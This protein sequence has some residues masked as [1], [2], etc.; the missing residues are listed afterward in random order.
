MIVGNKPLT[1]KTV[2]GWVLVVALLLITLYGITL[3]PFGEVMTWA[4]LLYVAFLCSKFEKAE[5]EEKKYKRQ[6]D[7]DVHLT[8]FL[9]QVGQHAN[10]AL[11]IRYGIANNTIND[12][13]KS[14]T[15]D[16]KGAMR[17]AGRGTPSVVPSK[18]ILL[19]KI[20]CEGNNRYI[21]ELSE[22]GDR[23]AKA[24]IEK[25]QEYVKT[26]LPL[27]DQWFEEYEK[28]EECLKH[29]KS[30]SLKEL[31]TFHIQFVLGSTNLKDGSCH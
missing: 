19:K 2:V 25:G 26:F 29:N 24:V 17:D 31:A 3:M 12:D 30:F 1:L 28:L 18:T 4:M 11:A 13:E 15:G 21:V 22:H 27:D 20:K 6:R 8:P 23:K 10:E 14:K 7:K 9:Y 5:K 16:R